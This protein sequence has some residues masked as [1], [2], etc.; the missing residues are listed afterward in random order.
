MD[1]IRCYDKMHKEKNKNLFPEK[2]VS[3][4]G[5]ILNQEEKILLVKPSYY[6]FWHLP[7]GFVDEGESPLEAVSREI[8]E[9]IN[10]VLK[11]KRLMIVDYNSG[12]NHKKEVIVFVFDFG[13]IEQIFF[14]GLT[15][16]NTEIIDYGFFTKEEAIKLVGPA[17]S[18]RLQ[19]SYKAQ[20]EKSFHYLNDNVAF[21]ET[22]L[23]TI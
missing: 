12:D 11:P 10:L 8:F 13:N 4:I 20:K 16:D 22:D 23:L 21:P 15:V 2:R 3:A 14:E 17:R 19:L 6:E 7:G 1:L 5:F 18:K 9:E